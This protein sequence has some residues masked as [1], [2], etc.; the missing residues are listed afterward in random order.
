MNFF[1][2]KNSQAVQGEWSFTARMINPIK[3]LVKITKL[4]GYIPLI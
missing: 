4:L 1:Q 3:K 2:N